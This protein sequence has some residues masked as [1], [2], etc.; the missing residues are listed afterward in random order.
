MHGEPDHCLHEA[1][2]QIDG[3]PWL[4]QV[5]CW[6]GN[7]FER[8]HAMGVAHGEFRPRVGFRAAYVTSPGTT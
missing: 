6:C 3:S 1:L 2:S 8:N 7:L 4:G 5:C